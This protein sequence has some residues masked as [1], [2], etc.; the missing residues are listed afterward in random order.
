[1]SAESD[2][3]RFKALIPQHEAW[4]ARVLEE[5]RE[6]HSRMPDCDDQARAFAEEST[7]LHDQELN[8]MHHISECK[9]LI[10]FNEKWIREHAPVKS[11]SD[12][13]HEKWDLSF[14]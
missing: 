9:R 12:K 11:R 10:A 7:R 4:L 13:F 3:E 8:A 1:M 5:L 14:F 2:I 6:L